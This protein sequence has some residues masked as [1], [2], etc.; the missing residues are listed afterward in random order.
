[1]YS[2]GGHVLWKEVMYSEVMERTM[3]TVG[4]G[5]ALVAA[6]DAAIPR[7]FTGPGLHEKEPGSGNA[8]SAF[9]FQ[10][11]FWHLH[12]RQ[13]ASPGRKM[14]KIPRCLR[15]TPPAR[16]NFS[17]TNFSVC[18]YFGPWRLGPFRNMQRAGGVG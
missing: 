18:A 10:R 13:C 15:E 12:A 16:T 8:F 2:E 11:V 1:M 5:L 4:D 14:C 6:V 7:P 3:A 9:N 17:P